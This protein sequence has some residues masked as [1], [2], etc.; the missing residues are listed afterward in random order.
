V[1]GSGFL[2]QPHARTEAQLQA[3]FARAQ[4]SRRALSL[5]RGLLASLEHHLPEA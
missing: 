2:T 3:L 1:Q 4:P 5:L